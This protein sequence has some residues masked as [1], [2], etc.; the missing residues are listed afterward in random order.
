[1]GG[2]RSCAVEG[3][4]TDTRERLRTGQARPSRNGRILTVLRRYGR[5]ALVA[6]GFL[7][8]NKQNGLRPSQ[9]TP[10]ALGDVGGSAFSV[11]S[12][13]PEAASVCSVVK[14][15]GEILYHR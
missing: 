13:P 3:G 15:T 6:S 10:K 1:M 12:V 5:D 9:N 7:P 14:T 11:F 8:R 4:R 2:P